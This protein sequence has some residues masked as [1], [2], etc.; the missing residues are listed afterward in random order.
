MA[1]S[2][3]LSD[4]EIME[5]L[6]DLD[7]KYEGDSMTRFET[8]FLDTITRLAKHNSYYLSSG[9]REHGLRILE[10]YDWL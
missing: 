8:G 9:Q 10:K 5:K 6:V 1:N 2:V 7:D 3:V 4:K